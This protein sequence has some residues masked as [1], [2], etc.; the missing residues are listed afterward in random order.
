MIPDRGTTGD[1][2]F[3]NKEDRLTLNIGNWFQG[4]GEKRLC[5]KPFVVKWDEDTQTENSQVYIHSGTL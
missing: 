2:E 5:G 1:V 4:D 3:L